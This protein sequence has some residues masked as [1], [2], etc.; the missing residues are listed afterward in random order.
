VGKGGAGYKYVRAAPLESQSK[1]VCGVAYVIEYNRGE[2]IGAAACAAVDP[3][4]FE[5]DD[6]GVAV[7]K[8]GE[9]KEDDRDVYVKEVEDL[10]A[11]RL[12]AESCPVQVI[13]IYDKKTHELVAP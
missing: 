11:A 7:L 3:A 8:G 2:C 6:T 5:M 10:D 4:N 9:E 12:A 1:D 13:K